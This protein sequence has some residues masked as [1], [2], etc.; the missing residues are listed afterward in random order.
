MLAAFV[1]KVVAAVEVKPALYFQFPYSLV[2][3][4]TVSAGCLSTRY[5]VFLPEFGFNSQN[6]QVEV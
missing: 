6:F 1:V 5:Y 2:N 3:L 4:L